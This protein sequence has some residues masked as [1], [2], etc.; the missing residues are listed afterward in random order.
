MELDSGKFYNQLAGRDLIAYFSNQKLKSAFVNGN[1][2]TIFFPQEEKNTDS[3]FVIKRKGMNR[4]Y[5]GD[6]RLDL[7]SGE[8][9]GVS[10]ID[11][12]DGKFYP[13]S[14]IN[15]E[16]Q[17]INSFRWNPILRP[18]KPLCLN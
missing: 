4:L 5:A 10:Y 12:P 2:Q 6:L 18:K 1:A 15:K 17:F 16:E 13:I 11:K 8:V 9:R 7:D 14:K 3:V